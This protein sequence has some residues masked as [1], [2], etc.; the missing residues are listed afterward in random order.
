MD[1]ESKLVDAA[2]IYIRP[3]NWQLFPRAPIRSGRITKVVAVR[4]SHQALC[5]QHQKL[6]APWG[7]DFQ[8]RDPNMTALVRMSSG[9]RLAFSGSMTLTRVPG[10]YS[11]PRISPA[12][13]GDL[14][15]LRLALAVGADV[16]RRRL[17]SPW[18]DRWSS[19]NFHA[20]RPCYSC[21]KATTQRESRR[22]V[23][24]GQVSIGKA[25]GV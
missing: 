23:E 8:F 1:D 9:N 11:I 22:V 15:S 21:S 17:L 25:K 2:S 3:W 18:G 5:A 10:V 4:Q 20:K 7:T 14:E 24:A 12:E 19:F 16:T 6:Q 13:T